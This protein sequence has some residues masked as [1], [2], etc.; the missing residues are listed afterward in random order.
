MGTD[1]AR[2][3]LPLK[4]QSFS[5]RNHSVLMPHLEFSDTSMVALRQPHRTS[6]SQADLFVHVCQCPQE[7]R[8]ILGKVIGRI[9]T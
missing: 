7:K 4:V 5:P 1:H 8:E 2:W 9:H 6:G 3:Y